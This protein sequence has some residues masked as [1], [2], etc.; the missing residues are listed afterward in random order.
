MELIFKESTNLAAALLRA[1]GISRSAGLVP[2][3]PICIGDFLFDPMAFRGR[4]NL[5]G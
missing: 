4:V 5:R 1:S 3:F 2:L